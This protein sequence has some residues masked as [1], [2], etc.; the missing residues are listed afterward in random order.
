MRSRS[1]LTSFRF[2]TW[3][4]YESEKIPIIKEKAPF[5]Y[6]YGKS[7]TTQQWS[8]IARVCDPVAGI[9]TDTRTAESGQI[10]LAVSNNLHMYELVAGRQ[11][12]H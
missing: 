7:E 6:I 10:F 12:R 9:Y 8:F 3:G 11:W 2:L 1:P 5:I 4:M